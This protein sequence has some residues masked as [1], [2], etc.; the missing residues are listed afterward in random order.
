MSGGEGVL[1]SAD[2]RFGGFDV[3]TEVERLMDCGFEVDG[4]GGGEGHIV[5][6]VVVVAGGEAR[7]AGKADLLLG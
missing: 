6:E 3:G 1:G 5:G 4:W 2:L 7:Y